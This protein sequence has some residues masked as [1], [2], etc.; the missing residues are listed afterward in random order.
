MKKI[1]QVELEEECLI[2]PKLSLQTRDY[3]QDNVVVY[4]VHQCEYIDFCKQV[5]KAWEETKEVH[6]NDADN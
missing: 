4:K 5:R 6:K 2:C 1:L 3:Y